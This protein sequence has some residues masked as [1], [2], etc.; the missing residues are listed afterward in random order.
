MMK[1]LMNAKTPYDILEENP[2]NKIMHKRFEEID[3]KYNKFLLKAKK[4]IS[5]EILFFKYAGDTSMSSD[6]ANGLK[7]AFPDKIIVVIYTKGVKANIS[8]R[9]KNVRD[10]ILKTIEGFENATGGGHENAVGAQIRKEDIP[11][12]EK[13][14]RRFLNA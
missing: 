2:K 8:A 11:E 13:R 3:K 7:Y 9:G 1:F 4:N 14:I 5:G 6:I 10:L 12:F